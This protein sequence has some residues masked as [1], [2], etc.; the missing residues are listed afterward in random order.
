MRG[1]KGAALFLVYRLRTARCFRP[2]ATRRESPCAGGIPYTSGRKPR[3]AKEAVLN[4]KAR[5]APGVKAPALRVWREWTR[6]PH[7]ETGVHTSNTPSRKRPPRF[8]PYTTRR[9]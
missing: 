9:N 6:A 7:P 2:V 1:R 8:N 5:V 4:N 3:R